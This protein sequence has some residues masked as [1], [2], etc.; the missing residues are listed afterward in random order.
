MIDLLAL[1]GDN[2]LKLPLS[3]VSRF[4]LV[5]SS[6]VVWKVDHIALPVVVWRAVVFLFRCLD[7]LTVSWQFSIC[8]PESG[9]VIGKRVHALCVSSVSALQCLVV[10]EVNVLTALQL[11]LESEQLVYIIH[12]VQCILICLILLLHNIVDFHL[13]A[14]HASSSNIDVRQRGLP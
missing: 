5:I 7:K 8:L 4:E 13:A 3:W 1:L 6:R 14:L 10:I 11:P 12:L 9:R 2:R